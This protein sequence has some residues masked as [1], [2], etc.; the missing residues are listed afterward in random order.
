MRLALRNA[1]LRPAQVDYINAHATGTV[2]GDAAEMRAIKRLMLEEDGPSEGKRHA[3][4]VNVSSSKGALGHLLGAA[5]AIE[6]LISILAIKN[7]SVFSIINFSP[8]Q[9]FPLSAYIYQQ[10]HVNTQ[11]PHLP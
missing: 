2:A 11:Y 8:C 5:G 1:G 6:A 7:V 4:D 3:A 9:L 10:R